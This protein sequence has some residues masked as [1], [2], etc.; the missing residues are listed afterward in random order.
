M[1]DQ[2]AAG[3]SVGAKQPK[4]RIAA[5]NRYP[6]YDLNSALILAR[7]VKEKGGNACTPD[8]LG[9]HLG[10]KNTAGGGF[11]GRV[12]AARAFGLIRTVQGHYETTPRAEAIL[13]PVTD[14]ARDQ[15]LRDAF[16]DIPLYR[17]IY[18]RHRGNQL[19]QEFG[20][21]NLLQTQYG[22]PPGDRVAL[23]YRVM[24]DSADTAGFFRAHNGARTH[25]VDPVQGT[26]AY[27]APLPQGTGQPK[28]N[29][30]GGGGRGGGTGGREGRPLPKVI[31]G[32]LELLPGGD[33]WDEQAMDD[34]FEFFK[35]ALRLAYKVRK[36]ETSVSDR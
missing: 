18:E 8:Q 26:P 17:Q 2:A 10:Y 27:A 5:E 30:G 19:P 20:M 11:V 22:V 6:V 32:A 13:Y 21:R 15:A 28:P 36:S 14:Q 23:A 33:A 29:G 7:A 3:A 31:E 24:M 35:S 25:L 4:G 12:A 16:L 9:G 34:W 1:S